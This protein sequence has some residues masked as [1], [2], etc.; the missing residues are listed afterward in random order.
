MQTSQQSDFEKLPVFPIFPIGVIQVRVEA[1][2]VIGG[3]VAK[4][5]GKVALVTGAASGVYYR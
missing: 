5:E 2:T 3:K 1:L 4:F